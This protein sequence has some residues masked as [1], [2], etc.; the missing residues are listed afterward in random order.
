M[1]KN[2]MITF[3]ILA[4]GTL[5]NPRFCNN[6]KLLHV[7]T[8]RLSI[9]VCCAYLDLMLYENVRLGDVF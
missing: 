9:F 4:A 2:G 5:I 7:I 8:Q 3:S 6:G 1:L